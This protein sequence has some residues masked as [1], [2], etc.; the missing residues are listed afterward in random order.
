[1][2]CAWIIGYAKPSVKNS[3]KAQQKPFYKKLA[4]E[5]LS[6]AMKKSRSFNRMIHLHE[7]VFE[8]RINANLA[9]KFL[10]KRRKK[11]TIKIRKRRL[12]K[13]G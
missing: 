2:A 11:K 10:H 1:M 12:Y 13:R 4:L 5:L 8:N 3:T 9:R 7:T 6:S